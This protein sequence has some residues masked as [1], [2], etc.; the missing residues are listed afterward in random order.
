MDELPSKRCSPNFGGEWTAK[1]GGLCGEAADA[2]GQKKK[3]PRLGPLIYPTYNTPRRL[4]CYLQE[5]RQVDGCVSP[6]HNQYGGDVAD[7]R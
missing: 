7:N 1:S 2:H 3:E 6:A 4:A 5:T